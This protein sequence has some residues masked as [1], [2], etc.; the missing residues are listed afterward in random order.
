VQVI[1]EQTGETV[2]VRRLTGGKAFAP[3]V[4]ARGKYAVK[5]GIDR[6]D[7]LTLTA[8]EPVAR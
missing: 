8:Q 1:A 6:P 5:I 3:P 4:F 2:Y 7:Q